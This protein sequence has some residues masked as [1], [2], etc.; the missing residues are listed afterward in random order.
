MYL[1]ELEEKLAKLASQVES[2]ERDAVRYYTEAR[3]ESRSDSKF[4]IHDQGAGNIYLENVV[5]DQ[6]PQAN[7]HRFR[8][9]IHKVV[10]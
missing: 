8:F 7:E 4:L 1:K 5:N 10:N 6:S 9:M 3:I 2:L